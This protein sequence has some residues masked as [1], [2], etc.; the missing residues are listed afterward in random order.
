MPPPAFD[1]LGGGFNGAILDGWNL[2]AHLPCGPL[3][4]I[5][6]NPMIAMTLYLLST[7]L[8]DARETLH[9]ARGK[10]DAWVCE[11]RQ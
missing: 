3:G 9:E 4:S 7:L 10:V 8:D 5:G 2:G 11:V 1:K 6:A